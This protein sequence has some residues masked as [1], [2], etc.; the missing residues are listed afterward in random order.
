MTWCN[1]LFPDN[2]NLFDKVPSIKY[3][4]EEIVMRSQYEIS[5]HIK[6]S[7][8]KI[9]LSHSINKKGHC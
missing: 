8:L 2:L 6:V 7:I 3:H 1:D 9:S 4:V 5:L